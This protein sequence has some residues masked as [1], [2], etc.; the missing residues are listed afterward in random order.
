MA[1]RVSLCGLLTGMIQMCYGRSLKEQTKLIVVNNQTS[2]GCCSKKE[3][4]EMAL[5]E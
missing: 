2:T 3:R 4:K 1:D 5:W